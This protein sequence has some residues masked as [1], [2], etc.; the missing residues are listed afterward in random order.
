MTWRL[1]IQFL[2]V[3]DLDVKRNMIGVLSV[4]IEQWIE[5][6]AP[7]PSQEGIS[8]IPFDKLRVPR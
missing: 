2:R 4:V 7:D 3:N 6:H 1:G 5:K 8:R